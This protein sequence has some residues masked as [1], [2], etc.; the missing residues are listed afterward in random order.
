LVNEDSTVSVHAIKLGPQDGDFYAVESGLSP[1][2]RVVT[3]GADRLRDGAKV[4][5]PSNTPTEATGGGGKGQRGGKGQG[6]WKGTHGGDSGSADQPNR[7]HHHRPQQGTSPQ[8]DGSQQQGASSSQGASQAQPAPQ[9]QT[10]QD[11]TQ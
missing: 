3:G 9:R 11:S 8:P 5:L 4:T 7:Q 1:G 2:D 6:A 10:Q